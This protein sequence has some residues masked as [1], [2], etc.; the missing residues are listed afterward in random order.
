M[1][2]SSRAGYW[3]SRC[4]SST[5]ICITTSA[6]AESGSTIWGSGCVTDRQITWSS[7]NGSAFVAP[8]YLPNGVTI[9]RFTLGFTDFHGTD[10][11]AELVRF[12]TSTVPPT[13]GVLASTSSSGAA[14]MHAETSDTSIANSVVDN[15]QFAYYARVSLNVLPT[16]SACLDNVEIA[17]TR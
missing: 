14:G 1:P 6:G 7:G 10:F 15:D 4:P 9:T 5:P 13:V 3:W 16:A 2:R 8:V 17:Y 11:P 12:S